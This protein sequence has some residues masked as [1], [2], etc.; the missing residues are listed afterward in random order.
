MFADFENLCLELVSPCLPGSSKPTHSPDL[1][2]ATEDLFSSCCQRGRPE[3]KQEEKIRALL[4]D[5]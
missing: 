3:Y 4:K 1:A 5:T 2:K